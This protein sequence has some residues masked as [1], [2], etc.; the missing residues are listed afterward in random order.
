MTTQTNETVVVKLSSG[1]VLVA[2]MLED[3]TPGLLVLTNVARLVE[4][5]DNAGAAQGQANLA[6]FPFMPF[7]KA[8]DRLVVGVNQIVFMTEPVQEIIDNHAGH[9]DKVRKASGL[10]TPKSGLV[11]PGKK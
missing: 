4:V 9:F 7:T 11:L 5:H 10:V 8:V 3:D 6:M 1:E 2:N